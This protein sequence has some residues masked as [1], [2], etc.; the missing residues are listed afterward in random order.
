MVGFVRVG[1]VDSPIVIDDKLDSEE[2]RERIELAKDFDLQMIICAPI[3][4]EKMT[5]LEVKCVND[6]WTQRTGR[7]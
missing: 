5:G 7:A 4:Q 1:L 2:R 6:R 3:D